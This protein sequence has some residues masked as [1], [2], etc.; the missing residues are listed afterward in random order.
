M[1]RFASDLHH[2]RQ[3][4]RNYAEGIKEA[5]ARTHGRATF[6][7][8]NTVNESVLVA[9]SDIRTVLHHPPGHDTFTLGSSPFILGFYAGEAEPVPLHSFIH[10]PCGLFAHPNSDGFGICLGEAMPQYIPAETLL[11]HAYR[12]LTYQKFNL[13]SAVNAEIVRFVLEQPPETFP[14]DPRPLF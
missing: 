3:I 1:E 2:R 14:T 12:I 11:L 7:H 5:C 9:L 4:L 13:K 6:L 8:C 10:V